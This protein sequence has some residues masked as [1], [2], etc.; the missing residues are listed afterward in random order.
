MEVDMV[1]NARKKGLISAF[2]LASILY[3][4]AC[5]QSPAEPSLDEKARYLAAISVDTASVLGAKQ[6]LPGWQAYSKQLDADWADLETKWFRPM[7]K[8]SRSELKVQET[9]TLFYP[10]SGPDMA[11][12]YA[13]FPD[14][15]QYVLIGLEPTGDL[16]DFSRASDAE[17]E[18]YLSET[19]ISIKDIFVRGYFITRKMTKGMS[20]Q[21]FIG[22]LP[23][24]LVFL[25]R[26]NNHVISMKRVYIDDQG[27]VQ[28]DQAALPA[29]KKSKKIRGISIDF[30]N[31]EHMTPQ[32]LYYFA[33]DLSDASLRKKPHFVKYLQSLGPVNTF[34]KSASYL[35]HYNSFETIRNAV[36]TQ[37]KSVMQEDSGIAYKYFDPAKW[38][39][40]LYG[41]Y[42][43]PVKDFSGVYQTDLKTEYDVR[44]AS[45]PKPLG[46][47]MGYHWG[48]RKS[49]FMLAVPKK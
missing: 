26:M 34:L 24:F 33:V 36:L 22:T 18:E 20:E 49:N 40:K 12:A 2:L 29:D 46:F 39:T 8:W 4:A 28:E 6:A 38:E 15:E 13:F 42:V 14:K 41:V 7:R 25:E 10:F 45:A 21:S 11:F 31:R 44:T 23:V 30:Q 43:E 19:Q 5:A 17:L 48:S 35:L 27:R 37:S 32:K 1:L 16:P 9:D 47:T 3:S